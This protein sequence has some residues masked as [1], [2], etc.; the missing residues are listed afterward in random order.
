MAYPDDEVDHKYAHLLILDSPRYWTVGVN[1]N[2]G[3]LGRLVVLAKRRDFVDL[4]YTTTAER[5]E[6][7]DIILPLMCAA[8]D[9]LFQPDLYNYDW[10][11]NIVALP[12]WHLVP[13]YKTPRTF[14]GEN[15]RDPTWG[16]M[17]STKSEPRSLDT[18][19]GIR[20]AIREKVSRM[21]R[22]W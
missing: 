12:H 6:F 9:G 22:S 10:L 8:L 7:F 21:S 18:I 5:E 4:R 14:M 3:N 11:G 17:W 19:L 2:Q 15:F 13:R 16:D 1:E 20:D